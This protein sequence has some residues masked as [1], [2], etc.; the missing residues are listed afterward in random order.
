MHKRPESLF[1]HPD[2]VLI[3]DWHE[4]LMLCRVPA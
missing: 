1:G 4:N 2:A 3:G